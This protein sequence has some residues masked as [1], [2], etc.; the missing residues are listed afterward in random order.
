MFIMC[1]LIGVDCEE[2]APSEPH[3]C[4]KMELENGNPCR[5]GA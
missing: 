2:G 5:S 1:I 3:Y 4:S